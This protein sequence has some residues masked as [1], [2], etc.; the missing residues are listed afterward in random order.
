[1]TVEFASL[2]V[3]GIAILLALKLATNISMSETAK[4]FWNRYK[5]KRETSGAS[6]D[7]PTATDKA[8]K[9]NTSAVQ[10]PALAQQAATEVVGKQRTWN[11]RRR[12]SPQHRLEF[13]NVS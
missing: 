11:I 9:E 4:D 5:H 7:K 13:G 8:Q 10:Q 1:M 2:A 6:S 3:T 12:E